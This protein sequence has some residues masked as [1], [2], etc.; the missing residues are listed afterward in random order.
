M[1]GPAGGHFL[2]FSGQ[3]REIIPF[4][5]RPSPDPERYIIMAGIKMEETSLTQEIISILRDNA[6]EDPEG[7]TGAEWIEA[8]DLIRKLDPP[9]IL[10]MPWC[11]YDLEV[12]Q[13]GMTKMQSR[14]DSLSRRRDLDENGEVDPEWEPQPRRRTRNDVLSILAWIPMKRTEPDTTL[15]EVRNM[16]TDLNARDLVHKV[17][18]F[19][20]VDVLALEERLIKL[21]ENAGADAPKEEAQDTANFTA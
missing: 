14:Y 17:F 2:L 1:S 13:H 3:G 18:K 20:G 5:A 8:A 15:E 11:I 21:A 12:D 10:D 19:W 16:M 6:S 9:G 7:Y 4:R